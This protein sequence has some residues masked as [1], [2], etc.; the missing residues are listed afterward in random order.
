MADFHPCPLCGDANVEIYLDGQDRT[1]SASALGPSRRDTSTG[2]ILR[3]RICRFGF[4]QLRPGEVELSQLYSG[5][6][7]N[8]YESE[9]RGRSKTAL[10]HLSIVQQYSRPGRLL[11]VGCASGA[12]LGYAANA[13]WAVVGIEPSATAYARARE[14]LPGRSELICATL[15]EAQLPASAFDV[16]TLWDVLEHVRDPAQFLRLCASLLKPGGHLFV[17]VP[18]LDSLQARLFGSHWPLLLQEHLNYFNRTSLKLCG[19]QAGLTWLRF[20][21]R[22]ASFS[23]EYVLY[24]LAQH[25]IFGSS[26]FHQF[27]SR[28]AIGKIVIS[29]PLGEIYG[30]WKRC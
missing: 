8:V 5:L 25:R 17:N 11:E 16:V 14:A 7:E 18:D 20:G 19:E 9:A 22:P 3:C 12:F 21:R 2:R 10:R 23:I 1:L 6:D 27:A 29:A 4:R 15:Q 28:R 30:V 26:I 13:G 24:R